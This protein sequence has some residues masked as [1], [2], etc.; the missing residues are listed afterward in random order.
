MKKIYFKK[1]ITVSMF[2]LLIFFV[3]FSQTTGN[4]VIRLYEGA[5][6][7][8]E[9]WD[10]DEIEKVGKT[11]IILTNVSVPTLTVFEPE[12]S[13][14]TGTAIV[15]CPGGGFRM[16]S[17]TNEGCE[18]AKWLNSKGITAFVLKYRLIPQ[19][20]LRHINN[21]EIDRPKIVKKAIED[22]KT[23]VAYVRNNAT[24]WDLKANQIGIMG[25]SAGGA[26]ASGVVY[27]CD[28]KSH[29]DFAAFIYPG[30]FGEA[31]LP[32][33]APPIFIAMA[34]DDPLKLT[35]HSIKLYNEWLSA[36]KSAELHIYRKG[37]HGFGML[38]KDI[39]T[40]NW[41]DRFYEW[42][43]DLEFNDKSVKIYN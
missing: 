8:S 4:K 3:G 7:G 20:S 1:A 16:L 10:W 42:L 17:M 23:A 21:I 11:Q 13:I 39:P 6:P 12:K 35:T 32:S 38:K 43:I 27:K 9:K 24:I 14:A 40:D 34:S 33:D 19:G 36:G 26:V 25:F 5:A 28:K 22:G 18:V 30:R 37:G 29:P 41:I 15:V 2:C 31:E